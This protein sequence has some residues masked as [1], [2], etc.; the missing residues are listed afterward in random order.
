MVTF[1]L[2]PLLL[3]PFFIASCVNPG[4]PEHR[5]ERARRMSADLQR[6]SP[7][8]S[9]TEADRLATTAIEA[10][11]ELSADFK[12][13][14]LPWVNNM[15]VN[16][17]LRKRGLCYQW[18]DDLFPH[19]F[20]LNL[21]TMDLH[22][23]SAKRATRRE[24]NGIIVTAKGQPFEEGLVLDPWRHG[25]R[26]WWG[27]LEKDRHRYPWEPLPWE[28]TPVVLRPLLMP[29]LYPSRRSAALQQEQ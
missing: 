6:L 19:L 13:V 8:V 15:L 7:S 16:M 28:L 18:R 24:H 9:R 14:I 22:L 25:G 20:R 10:S 23:T 4:T 27:R 17:G 1:P 12:P 5:R 3:V 2:R 11:A 29:D 26:L 21:R